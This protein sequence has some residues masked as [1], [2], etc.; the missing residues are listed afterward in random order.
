MRTTLFPALLGLVALAGTASAQSVPCGGDF[1]RFI[2]GLKQEAVANGHSA[3]AADRFFANVRRDP[4]VIAADNSQ[5]VFR[6]T[7]TDFS[8]ALISGNRMA[9]GVANGKKYAGL[10]KEA[11]RRYGVPPGVI[12]AF[13]GFET[14]YGAVQGNFNTANALVTLA[15][16]CRRP[17]LFRPQ[18]FAALS[19]YEKG[20]F[21]P[22]TTTGAWAG[23]I[24]M[25]QMLPKDILERGVD[26]DGDGRVTLKTSIP[27]AIMSGGRMLADHGWRRGEP[28]LQEVTVP[29]QMDWSLSGLDT[30]R[31]AADWLRMGVKPRGGGKVAANLNAALLL[32]Q[33]RK[34]PAFLAYPN[35]Y[36]FFDWNKSFV[37]VTTAAYFA[38]RLS[39]P[40]AFDPG[41]PDP[42]LTDAQMTLL[43]QKLTARG[44]NVGAIDGV[45]GAMTRSAV[46]KEQARLGLPADAWP[47]RTLLDRL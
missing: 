30:P 41:N 13:W 16:D 47:T 22:A 3:Q 7:F 17:D 31:P 33:G 20:E 6:K 2:A 26:G 35:Y 15:H 36:V 21:D 39:G 9:N 42:P 10:L 37:Y 14:D 18:V 5:G 25:I 34:G 28:W 44:Y 27:D 4:K 43:Q 29:D 12:L 46:Q 1:G 19:L 32:P 24:G 38:T 8:R 23:E 11:E 40:P 45:L